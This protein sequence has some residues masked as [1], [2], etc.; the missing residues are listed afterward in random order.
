MSAL[1][2]LQDQDSGLKTKNRE[3]PKEIAVFCPLKMV[4]ARRVELLTFCT[5]SKRATR[6]RYAPKR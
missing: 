5:P 3:I 2:Q 6:L 4:G 1:L